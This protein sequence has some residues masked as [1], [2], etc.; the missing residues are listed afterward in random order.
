LNKKKILVTGGS[1]LLATN[2][3]ISCANEFDVVLGFHQKIIS[4][5]GIGGKVVD[6]ETISGFS[7]ALIDCKP[8]LVIHCAGLANVEVCEADAVFAQHVNVALSRNVA[9]ACKDLGIHLVYV[10]T[11]HLFSGNTPLVSE[12]EN[13]SPLNQYGKTKWEGEKAVLDVSDNFLAVRTNF[14]GWGPPY[15]RSFSDMIIDN[16]RNGKQVQLFEDFYYTPIL[17]E[18]LAKTVMLLCENKAQGVFNVVGNE[19][20]SKLEFGIRLAD[21][22]G[23]DKDLIEI[24]KFS[25]RKDLVKRPKD[26]SLSNKKA[27]L[28]LNSNIGD[29]N[30]GIERLYQ[31]EQSGVAAVLN[32]L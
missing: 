20:I 8:D 17:V 21:R 7:N 2:W 26:L 25:E 18:E 31:Q 11:D 16:L 1:G 10:C 27:E 4:L 3:A 29:V 24:S 9:V 6:M 14:Y 13:P 12:T 30:A 28:F 5:P 19:R 32:K 22:F 15:R 23:L